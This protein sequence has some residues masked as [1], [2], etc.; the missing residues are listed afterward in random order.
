MSKFKVGD[1]VIVSNGLISGHRFAVVT[2]TGQFYGDTYICV[3][4]LD[5]FEY[6]TIPDTLRLCT[7][8]N[9]LIYL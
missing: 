2:D 8:L 6:Y 1:E 3:K 9:R 7:P 4:E 5:G